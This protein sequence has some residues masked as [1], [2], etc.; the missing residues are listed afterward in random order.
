MSY[1]CCCTVMRGT[2]VRPTTRTQT[3]AVKCEYLY[4]GH[5][6]WACGPKPLLGMP[7]PHV[8][9]DKSLSL[10]S[11]SSMTIPT[12]CVLLQLFCSMRSCQQQHQQQQQQQ[13]QV[14][15]ARE[16]VTAIR[17]AEPSSRKMH[18]SN[19]LCS[20]KPCICPAFSQEIFADW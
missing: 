4:R 15:V 6:V 5:Q 3:E 19:V 10:M 11:V 20:Q 9:I 14:T 16:H 18:K 8:S 1:T 17:T 7:K 2:H 13:Q 12:S